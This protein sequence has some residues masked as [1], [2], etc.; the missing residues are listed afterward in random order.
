MGLFDSRKTSLD[1]LKE[2]SKE[3]RRQSEATRMAAEAEQDKAEAMVEVARERTRAALLLKEQ[4]ER[5]ALTKQINELVFDQDDPKAMVANLSYLCSLVDGWLSSAKSERGNRTLCK[6]A[7]SKFKMGLTQLACVDPGNS[8]IPYLNGKEAEFQE[9]LQKFRKQARVK[10]SV[11]WGLVALTALAL[12]IDGLATDWDDSALIL[13]LPLFITL[14][15]ASLVTSNLNS[16][17][18]DD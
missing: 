6:A 18:G 9:K 10:L 7:E 13:L 3:S 11:S 4:E 16:I 12:V 5:S 17:D 1:Y 14:I 15:I 8:M 2:I